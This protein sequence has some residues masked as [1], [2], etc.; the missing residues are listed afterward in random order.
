MVGLAIQGLIGH[1]NDFSYYSGEPLKGFE[2][3][4]NESDLPFGRL[5]WL[6]KEKM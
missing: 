6:L 4:A 3:R 1:D 5:L 2:Q